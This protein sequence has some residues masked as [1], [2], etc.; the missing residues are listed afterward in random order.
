MKKTIAWLLIAVFALAAFGCRVARIDHV[1]DISGDPYT[2]AP[3]QENED[4]PTPTPEQSEPASPEPD[5][6]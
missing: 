1:A 2:D 3:E 5:P 4:L 6:S